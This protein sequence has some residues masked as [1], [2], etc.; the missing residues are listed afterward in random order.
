MKRQFLAGLDLGQERDYSALAVVE[1]REEEDGWDAARYAVK[2]RARLWVRHLE[3]I[4]LRTSYPAVVE[5]VRGAME[6]LAAEG[7]TRLAVDGTS[8]RP[9][10]DLLR[11]ARKGWE[12]WA[13]TITSGSPGGGPS[14]GYYRVGKRDLVVGLQVMLERREL[15]VA[16]G[17]TLGKALARELVEVEERGTKLGAFGEGRHD[18]LVTALSLA[19]W[20]GRQVW[21]RRLSGPAGWWVRE[22]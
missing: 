7:R 18:D 13:A 20:M 6:G 19:C 5:R 9:A 21:G 2:R 16:K 8:G 12:L 22:E 14:G 10:V 1:R 3:R 15:Q 17:L 11:A 4:P